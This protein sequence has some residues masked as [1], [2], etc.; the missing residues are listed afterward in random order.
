MDG[1]PITKVSYMYNFINTNLPVNFNTYFVRD[2]SIHSYGIT[3]S[4]K[5]RPVIFNTDLGITSIKHHGPNLWDGIGNDIKYSS[6]T[7]VFK[8]NYKR[9][10]L[11]MYA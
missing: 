2:N 7:S 4:N 10:I 11:L 5:L 1:T 9:Y 6:S 8:R 3:S